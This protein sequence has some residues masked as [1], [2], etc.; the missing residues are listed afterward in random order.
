M[1]L[2]PTLGEARL[3]QS[4]RGSQLGEAVVRV[5]AALCS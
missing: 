4:L 3:W 2:A 1:R 5:R